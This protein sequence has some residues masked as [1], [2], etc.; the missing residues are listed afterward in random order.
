MYCTV[1]ICNKYV[2]MSIVICTCPVMYSRRR[3]YY[4]NSFTIVVDYC[5]VE[6]TSVLCYFVYVVGPNIPGWGNPITEEIA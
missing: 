3:I 5:C 1:C 2:V 4:I 6:N